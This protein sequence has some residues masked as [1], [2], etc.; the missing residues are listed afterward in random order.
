M[1]NLENDEIDLGFEDWK[2]AQKLFKDKDLPT[3]DP[4]E[5]DWREQQILSQRI[6]SEG[7]TIEAVIILHG[8]LELELNRIWEMFVICNN[9]NMVENLKKLNERSYLDLT[10]LCEELGLF[11][12]DEN[13]VVEVLKEFNRLRNSLGHNFYGINQKTIPKIQVKKKFER[14]VSLAGLLPLLELK[15]LHKEAKQ[16]K[17]AKNFLKILEKEADEE[18][19]EK[20]CKKSKLKKVKKN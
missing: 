14:A 19:K 20:Y 7:K 16:N 10:S 8:L 4:Q 6:F 12:D 9:I 11:D 17:F 18:Y 2:R 3:K 1:T 5:L 15:F 13:E